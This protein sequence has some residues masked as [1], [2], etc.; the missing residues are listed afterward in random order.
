VATQL[1]GVA[2]PAYAG[3]AYAATVDAGPAYAVAKI[4]VV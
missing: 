3:P 2:R 1:A 4:R